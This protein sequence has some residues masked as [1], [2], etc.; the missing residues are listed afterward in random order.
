MLKKIFIFLLILKSYFCWVDNSRLAVIFLKIF[1]RLQI[2][3][4]TFQ[5]LIT[6]TWKVIFPTSVA[7]F[8]IFLFVF[9]FLQFHCD[10]TRCVFLLSCLDFLK[11]STVFDAI[12]YCLCFVLL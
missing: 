4:V 3:T 1:L 5:K 10:V 7:A 9:H 8:S 2:F 11:P 6:S 12:H